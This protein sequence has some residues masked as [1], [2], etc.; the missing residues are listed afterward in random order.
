MIGLYCPTPGSPGNMCHISN[1]PPAASV[2]CGHCTLINKKNRVWHEGLLYKLKKIGIG[3]NL[4]AFFKNYLSDRTQRVV[5]NGQNSVPG[6]IKAG[7][8]QGSVLG[9]LLFLIYINDITHNSFLACQG[10][11]GPMDVCA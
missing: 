6:F 2:T 7:V 9:P 11:I 10:R 1:S 3:G 4:L 8:P 5:I